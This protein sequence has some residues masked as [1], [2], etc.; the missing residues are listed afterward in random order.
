MTPATSVTSPAVE[1][2][3]DLFDAPSSTPAILERL[4]QAIVVPVVDGLAPY[5]QKI[6]RM[7]ESVENALTKTIDPSMSEE[8]QPIIDLMSTRIS[9]S[10]MIFLAGSVFILSIRAQL[11]A[12]QLSFFKSTFLLVSMVASA[13]SMVFFIIRVINTSDSVKRI[14]ANTVITET[15]SIYVMILGGLIGTVLFG[16]AMVAAYASLQI[17]ILTAAAILFVSISAIVLYTLFDIN[18]NAVL[19]EQ[20]SPITQQVADVT[21]NLTRVYLLS[22]SVV[23]AIMVLHLGMIFSMGKSQYRRI[24]YEEGM[25]QPV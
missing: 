23:A 24:A 13:S 7:I 15:S 1:T 6:M 22:C 2:Q 3:T 21:T 9:S 20:G 18:S 5:L 25:V 14:L 4:N 8:L 16:I 17:F 12:P 10:L 19:S 11:F